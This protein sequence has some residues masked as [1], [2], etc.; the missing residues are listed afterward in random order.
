MW[1]SI[2]LMVATVLLETALLVGHEQRVR[3]Y[4]VEVSIVLIPWF[5][6]FVLSTLLLREPQ[7]RRWH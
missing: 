7:V 4:L 6:T 1:L 3:G 2:V 5:I